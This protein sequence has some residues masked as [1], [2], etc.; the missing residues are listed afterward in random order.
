M[1]TPERNEIIFAAHRAA[2]P[3][4]TLESVAAQTRLLLDCFAEGSPVLAEFDKEAIRAEATTKTTTFYGTLLFVDKEIT[5]T[6]GVMFLKTRP[7]DHH[8]NGKELVRTDRT[9]TVEGQEVAKKAQTLVGHRVAV[10][11]RIEKAVIAGKNRTVR[12]VHA[13]VSNGVDPAF[14]PADPSYQPDYEDLKLDKMASRQPRP[15]PPLAA[16]PGAAA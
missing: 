7:S 5:S 16:L 2:G 8:P 6:R 11:M 15:A 3:G 14:N 10:T 1:S 9:D 12:V 4:A 13:I